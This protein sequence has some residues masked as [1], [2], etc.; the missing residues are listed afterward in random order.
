[1]QVNKVTLNNEINF[2][3]EV[4]WLETNLK[5]KDGNKLPPKSTL[6]ASMKTHKL[7][8]IILPECKKRIKQKSESTLLFI[9]QLDAVI[10]ILSERGIAVDSN[11][12]PDSEYFRRRLS[13]KEYSLDEIFAYLIKVA[14]PEEAQKF[15]NQVFKKHKEHVL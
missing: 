6:L 9:K 11:D 15:S 14:T 3:K 8:N 7:L 13:L 5:D 12:I 4:V 2:P 10:A 1:M